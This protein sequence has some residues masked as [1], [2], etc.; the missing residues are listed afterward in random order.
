MLV[1]N[2]ILL[3]LVLFMT[4][5]KEQRKSTALFSHNTSLHHISTCLNIYI[6]LQYLNPYVIAFSK[7]FLENLP[8]HFAAFLFILCSYV[9]FYCGFGTIFLKSSFIDFVSEVPLLSPSLLFGL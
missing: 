1:V 3:K 7:L 5:V 8:L 6:F 2:C 9:Y 4:L